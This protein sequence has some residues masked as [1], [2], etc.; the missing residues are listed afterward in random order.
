MISHHSSATNEHF[1]PA[2]YIIAARVLMGG[3]DLDPASNALANTIV[4]A[5][6]YFDKEMDGF[7]R[8]WHGRVWLNPPG[9][10]CDSLGRE[11]LNA[12][13]GKN[14]RL[15][16][17][18]SGACGLPPGHEHEDVT[19][20]TKAWYFKM[21]RQYVEGRIVSAV[22]MG[23]NLELL[24]TSQTPCFNSAGLPPVQRFP[25]CYPRERIRFLTPKGGVLV[26]GNQPTHANVI[27]YLPEK[28]GELERLR[29]SALF[30]DFGEC[31]WPAGMFDIRALGRSECMATSRGL[32]HE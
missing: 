1:T 3:I 31:M 19:S 18:V 10:L 14:P 24:Q 4:G 25:I 7:N 15:S 30:G 17:R 16:C 12:R 20:S 6:S 11:V 13:K 26:V 21:L 8:E 5:T 28:L 29:F 27:V 2:G 9:G 23:F 32:L 22:F